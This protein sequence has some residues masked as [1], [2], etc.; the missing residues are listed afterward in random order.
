MTDNSSSATLVV[1]TI[2]PPNAVMTALRDGA[3]AAGMRFLVIGDTKS[4]AGFSRSTEA[5]SSVSQN[6]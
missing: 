2:N 6:R 3:R 4:P 1:T 5:S